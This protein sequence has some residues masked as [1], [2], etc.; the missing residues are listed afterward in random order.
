M[1]FRLTEKELPGF[2]G[3]L[4]LRARPDGRDGVLGGVVARGPIGGGV[5]CRK[6]VLP[7]AVLADADDDGGGGGGSVGGDAGGAISAA[8]GTAAGGA[9]RGR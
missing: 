3:G 7:Y 1:L 5:L 8:E 6:R 4:R 2:G 9:E